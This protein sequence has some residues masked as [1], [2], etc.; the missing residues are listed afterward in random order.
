MNKHRPIRS[1][2]EVSISILEARIRRAVRPK[3]RLWATIW[4]AERLIGKE[5][6]LTERA[7]ALFAEAEQLA[8]SIGDRRGVAS[9]LHGAGNCHLNLFNFFAALES[10]ERALPIAEQTGYA[11][12][13]ILILRDMGIVYVRQSQQ[14][15]AMETLQ[16]C[17]E[18]AEL[19]ENTEVQVS[20]LNQ[21]GA[22]L[23]NLGRYPESLEYH[24][25]SLTLLDTVGVVRRGGVSRP[26]QKAPD[27]AHNMA[28][29]LGNLSNALWHLGRY[30][31]ALSALKRSSHLSHAG[32]R[33]EGL[34]QGSI[35]VIYSEIGDYPRALSSM[36]ACA[37]IM[38]RIGDKL[39][40]GI[41]YDNLM[42]VNRQLGN[43][44]QAKDYAEKALAIFEE[45]GYKR[46][47]AGMFVNLGEY[48]YDQGQRV[49]A[50]RML[51][52]CLALSKEVGSKD[53]ETTALTTRAKLEMEGGHFRASEKFFQRALTI[54]NETG[55]RD[56]TIAALLGLGSLFNKQRKPEPALLFLVR[57]ME[58]AE[59]IHS[60]NHEQEAHQLL[61]EAFEMR[62]AEGD[63]KRALEHSKLA[64]HIKEE[65]LGTKKQKAIAKLQVQAEIDKSEQE[66]EQL[67]K[68][69]EQLRKEMEGTSLEIERTITELAAKTEAIRNISRQIKE[70]AKPRR[71][72]QFDQLLSEIEHDHLSTA[73]KKI[74]NN[75]FEL[76]H[77]DILQKL[78]TRYPAL[79][80]TERKIC[81]LLREE[82][83][84]KEMALMLKVSTRA[85]EK[86]RYGI[87]KK[88]KLERE[89]SLTTMLATL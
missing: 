76:I 75:E 11:E 44:E 33:N 29:T 80:L 22:L 65:I 31:D 55:D 34:C 6:T 50:K 32:S 19:I 87:R 63:L 46:G 69:K 38:E 54:A 60:R 53:F 77:D 35:G 24:T 84:I 89:M 73:S 12:C 82:L 58:V 27:W 5:A 66:I 26:I 86:H 36:L 79:T 13:E 15:L 28:V 8:E 88:M 20:A 56:R 39:N 2:R 51:K 25:K 68:E 21:M 45:V 43:A 67:K 14:E 42:D 3:E 78:S 40:L 37:K 72:R 64:F 47:Q 10:L 85:I 81:V 30:A 18:I 74:F 83:S 16:K 71:I 9:A 62:E 48:H 61:A 49:L 41:T 59:E 4:L 70:I 23:M 7:L 52:Q 1:V 17:A 57:A